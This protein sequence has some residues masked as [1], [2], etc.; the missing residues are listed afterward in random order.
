MTVAIDAAKCDGC[1]ICIESCPVDV[2]RLDAATGKAVPVYEADCHV[3]CLCE[4]DCP[5]KAIDIDYS[6]SNPRQKSIYD[7]LDIP[8]PDITKQSL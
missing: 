2:L 8:T 5:T 4:D 7:T 3:C 1:G 6:I